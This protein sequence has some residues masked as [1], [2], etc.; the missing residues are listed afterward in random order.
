MSCNS[1]GNR[2]SGLAGPAAG[3]STAA[4]KFNNAYGSLSS[5]VLNMIDRQGLAAKIVRTPPVRIA[6]DTPLALGYVAGLGGAATL[7]STN[8]VV[9]IPLVAAGLVAANKW[10]AINPDTTKGAMSTVPTTRKFIGIPLAQEIVRVWQ[11]EENPNK[12]VFRSD[13]R[14]WECETSQLPGFDS[15][16]RTMT[17]LRAKTL[18]PQWYYFK[19]ELSDEEAVRV[20]AGN[21]KPFDLPGY[22]GSVSYTETLSPLGGIKH[23]MIR[24]SI[25]REPQYRN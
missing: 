17:T 22:A 1:N 4:C 19:G 16:P 20:A 21:Q 9:G 10:A 24:A 14:N 2:V 3:V 15:Q 11:D 5:N 6:K 7:I 18:P 13:R 25:Q 12:R 8:P 23:S